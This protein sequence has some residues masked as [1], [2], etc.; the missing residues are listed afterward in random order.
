MKGWGVLSG[1]VSGGGG[2]EH[3][4]PQ[5]SYLWDQRPPSRRRAAG[6][7]PGSGLWYPP[8]AIPEQVH[9]EQGGPREQARGEDVAAG[10]AVGSV[11]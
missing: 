6:V 5:P 2:R 1:G 8:P 4:E 9:V 11:D 10:Q 7:S 3:T